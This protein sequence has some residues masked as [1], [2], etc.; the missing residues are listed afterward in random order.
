VVDPSQAVV[1]QPAGR[2]HSPHQGHA[3]P[4]GIL[5]C[6]RQ[7]DFQSCLWPADKPSHGSGRAQEGFDV[8]MG[9]PLGH[10][11]CSVPD[12]GMRALGSP[13]H[14]LLRQGCARLP[15]GHFAG[16]RP[17]L[18]RR[19]L[20]DDDAFLARRWRTPRQHVVHSPEHFQ[21]IRDRLLGSTLSGRRAPR[22]RGASFRCPARSHS[23]YIS[24]AMVKPSFPICK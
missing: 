18:V 12:G 23:P 2:Q 4:W 13:W 22:D 3:R 9:R 1:E 24:S 11:P 6:A 7:S 19:A 17:H 14:Q 5:G 20:I 16:S 15:G 8:A 21:G 10:R